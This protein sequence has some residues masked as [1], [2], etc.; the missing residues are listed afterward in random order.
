MSATF[1]FVEKS[2]RVE[3]DE[4]NNPLFLAKDIC[5]I[6]GLNNVSQALSRLDDDE[7]GVILNDTPSK[8]QHGDFGTVKQEMSVVNESGLYALILSSRKP[9]AK[10]FR[11]WVTNEVIP[12]IRKTGSY[13][14]PNHQAQPP[15]HTAEKINRQQLD[16]I[17]SL[18]HQIS[19]CCHHK[20]VASWNVYA[21]IRETYG[22]KNGV[23]ELPAV[24]FN[25]VYG[26]L[27]LLNEKAMQYLTMRVAVDKQ[28]CK[29][30][31]RKRQLQLDFTQQMLLPSA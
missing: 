21:G 8:N 22:L 3:M 5:E 31:L 16:Q 6:L 11:K 28:F 15:E 19:I 24:H 30:V 23:Q 1:N 17:E 27:N 9:E 12:A 18:V 2:V 14:N 13:T 29:Q 25:A 7:R 26:F 20:T 10:K 4:N